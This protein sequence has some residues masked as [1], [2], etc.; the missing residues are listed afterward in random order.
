MHERCVGEAR[1]MHGGMYRRHTGDARKMHG[2]CAEA[3]R[4]THRGCVGDAWEMRERALL[5]SARRCGVLA[6]AMS[7]S[8]GGEECDDARV[9]VGRERLRGWAAAGA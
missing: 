2:G 9:N 8:F 5:G 6:C 4:E 7:V 3:A 1:E